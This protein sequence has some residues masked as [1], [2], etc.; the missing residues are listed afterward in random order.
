MGFCPNYEIPPPEPLIHCYGI[1]KT[2]HKTLKNVT[3]SCNKPPPP[4]APHHHL[5]GRM[6]DSQAKVQSTTFFLLSPQCRGN[7]RVLTFRSLSQGDFLLQRVW[8]KSIVLTSNLS[9]G[10]KAYCRALKTEK[11]KS[12]PFLLHFHFYKSHESCFAENFLVFKIFMGVEEINGSILQYRTQA[13]K[14]A[15]LWENQQ[16]GLGTGPTQTGLCMHRRWPET[17]NFGF[18]KKRNCTIQL[19]RSWSVSLFSHMQIVGFLMRWLK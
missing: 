2:R 10:S 3:D 16:C 19:P 15:T 1:L 9:P 7:V 4:P 6:G 5:W 17:G 8:V 12:P 11:S 18:R 13:I 14:W